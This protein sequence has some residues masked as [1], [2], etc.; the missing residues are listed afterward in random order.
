MNTHWS[1]TSSDKPHKV[2]SLLR[3]SQQNRRFKGTGGVSQENRSCGFVPAF[4]DS[5]TGTVYRSCFA[6]GRPAPMHLLDGLP[7]E[8]A[9]ERSTS[10][11][12]IAVK[13]CVQA[14]FMRE[15][16]FYTREQAAEALAEADRQQH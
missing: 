14:G 11:R 6:D 10:G 13:A 1:T 16:K 5:S 4:F 3:L 12:T 9:V 8:L 7:A 2:L 15:G